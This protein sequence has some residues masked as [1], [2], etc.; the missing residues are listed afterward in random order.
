MSWVYFIIVNELRTYKILFIHNEV[1]YLLWWG[2]IGLFPSQKRIGGSPLNVAVRLR[3]F[4]HQVC[5]ISRIG[6]DEDGIEICRFL[7]DAD[8]RAVHLQKDS[9]YK[10]GSASISLDEEGSASYSIDFP[11]A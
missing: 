4:G 5:L 7:K 3:P 11:S 2:F 8:I 6:K 9:M 10:T 1:Y